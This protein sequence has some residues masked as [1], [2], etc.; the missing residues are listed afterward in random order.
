MTTSNANLWVGRKQHTV[1]FKISGQGIFQN[2]VPLKKLALTA[3]EE[4]NAKEIII[5]LADCLYMDS[6]F[7]GTLVGI[8]TALLKKSGQKLIVAN[9]NDRS[10]HLLDN[11]GVSHII[12][13]RNN[14]E[15]LEIKWELIIEDPIQN[16]NLTKHILTAHNNL[17]DIDSRNNTRFELVKKLLL[18]SLKDEE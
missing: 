2:S 16:R 7:M 13:I 3:L 4:G 1:I 18:E 9:A 5:D 15:K 6:T 14:L 11:L 17:G 8:N 12:E 10:R